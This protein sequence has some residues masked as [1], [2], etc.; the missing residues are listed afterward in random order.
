MRFKQAGR[1]AVVW[2][3]ASLLCV[4]VCA[5]Y[6]DAA[7]DKKPADDLAGACRAAVANFRPLGPADVENAKKQLI[8]AIDRLDARLDLDGSNGKAWRAFLQ[9]PVL[10]SQLQLSGEGDKDVLIRVL[11][12]FNTG[13]DGLELVWFLDVQQALHHYL[14]W[15]NEVD[16]PKIR[17]IFEEKLRL[18]ADRLERYASKPT[19][20]DALVIGESLRLLESAGQTP[21]LV[22]AIGERY[23]RPN[24]I[25]SISPAILGAGIAESVDES[26]PVRDC[27]LG[28]D[29]YGTAHTVGR[30]NIALAP[31][32]RFGMFDV[33][34]LGNTTSD[35]VG[36]HG[37]V[38]IISQSTTS[39]SGRKR[40][41]IH[42]GG[43]SSESSV[44]TAETNVRLCDIQ[45]KR[46][47]IERMAWKRAGKQQGQAET[48]ASSH[49]VERLNER[50]D[51]QADNALQRANQA[52]SEKFVRPFT[53]RKLFPQQLQFSTTEQA[54]KLVALQAG[55]GK[56][57]APTDPPPV[58]EKAEMSLRLHESAI[59]NLAFDAMAGRTIYE[60]KVQAAVVQTLGKLPDKMKSP[61][62]DQPWAITF[63]ARQPISVTFADDGFSI[64]LRGLR[65][66]HGEKVYNEPMNITAV[67]KI[68]TTPRG[69]KAV[70]QGDIAVFPPDFKPGQG[71]QVGGKQQMFR[72]LL[73]N[74]FKKVFVAEILGEG[75][76]LAGRWKAAGTLKPIELV[77]RDGWLVIGWRRD[78]ATPNGSAEANR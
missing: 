73:Q 49:A 63:D 66:C 20:D 57:G 53:E 21:E 59:N 77:C 44:S 32:D 62:D 14:S 22:R 78:T 17:P 31:S 54:I 6:A 61:E 16:S 13:Y 19:T 29:I 24:L 5:A 9:L 42:P 40:V 65:F 55:G 12:H 15:C 56:L 52:Y 60:E 47:F 30:S 69:F 68:E 28:T 37:P 26:M 74:R 67:Y 1:P 39:L 43:I 23:I 75:F 71:Q 58:S 4:I 33:L 41:W 2:Y 18:L 11:N 48:I 7:D 45:A 38:T 51:Q 76:E 10:R 8:E 64:T 36:Y 3:L 27:I 34:F 70:L 72:T 35:N 46:S 50:I 25:G